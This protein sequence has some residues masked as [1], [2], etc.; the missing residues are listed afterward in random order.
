MLN[1]GLHPW[2][3]EPTDLDAHGEA[4]G[5]ASDRDGDGRVPNKVR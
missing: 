4:G 1:A 2:I 3:P 5:V